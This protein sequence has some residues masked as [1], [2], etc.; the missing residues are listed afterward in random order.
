MLHPDPRAYRVALVADAVIND[1]A[2]AFD[3]MAALE[4]HQFGII[5][6]P[7]SDFTVNSIGSIVEY[8]VDDLTDYERNGYRVVEIGSSEV[9][10]FGTWHAV[11]AAD[12]Q[13]RSHAG[14]EQF[15]VVGASLA[16]F[17]AFLGASLPPAL[18][19]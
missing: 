14:F 8:V 7:P 1:G 3:A 2:A 9:A 13:R 6:L 19:R 12:L 4:A 11:V 10:G 18:A 5:V 17:E 15:D 16:D